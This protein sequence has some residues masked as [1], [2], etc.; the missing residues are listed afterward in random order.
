M[1]TAEIPEEQ[2]RTCGVTTCGMVAQSNGTSTRPGQEAVQ[3]LLGCYIGNGTTVTALEENNFTHNLCPA[4]VCVC[5]GAGVLAM[6][7][8]AV[9]LD[10]IDRDR[11]SRFRE[12]RE[13][14]C[15]TFLATFRLL[16]DWRLLLVVPLTMYSGFEQSFLSGEYTKAGTLTLLQ[17]SR[18]GGE[19]RSSGDPITAGSP[20]SCG[21]HQV[22]EGVRFYQV[23]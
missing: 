12:K 5:V 21:F 19:T 15:K 11:A 7:I 14:F 20:F 16:K 17:C 1:F 4:C 3:T 22:D 6:L 10:D 23:V 9:F 8:V 2:L 13:P 18:W